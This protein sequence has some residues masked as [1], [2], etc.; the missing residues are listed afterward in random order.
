LSYREVRVILKEKGFLGTARFKSHMR[1]KKLW[2]TGKKR[3][4]KEL[5]KESA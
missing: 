5:T 2:S 4:L 1:E 3:F